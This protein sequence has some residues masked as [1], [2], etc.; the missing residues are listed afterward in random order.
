MKKII[1]FIITISIFNSGLLY[2][3]QL[4]TVLRGK[5]ISKNPGDIQVLITESDGVILDMTNIS[6]SGE[7][8]LDLTIMDLPSQPEVNKL[9][10]EVKNKSG[11]KKKYKLTNYLT[12]FEDTVLLRTIVFN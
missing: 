4:A 5:I 6:S 1:L 12:K 2:A 7:Y 11:T 8:T 10:V 9:I 3:E